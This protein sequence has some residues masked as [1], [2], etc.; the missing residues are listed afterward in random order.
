MPDLKPFQTGPNG[1]LVDDEPMNVASQMAIE[2]GLEKFFDFIFFTL[3]LEFDPA[4]NQVLHRSN[5][6]E[7]SRNRFDRITETN[8]LHA[9]VVENS[10]RDHDS[11]SPELR[12]K[13]RERT[14]KRCR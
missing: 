5:Y 11:P 8:S 3:D 13:T 6:V 7:P 14:G 4:I 12:L 1:N 9:S 2:N 10:P